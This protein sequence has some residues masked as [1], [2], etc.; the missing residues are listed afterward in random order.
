MNVASLVAGIEALNKDDV[1]TTGPGLAKR[2][3]TVLSGAGASIYAG[4]PSTAQ[5]TASIAKRRIAGEVLRILQSAD[6][7]RNFE[8]VLHVLEELELLCD[9]SAPPRATATLRPFVQI[10]DLG[11]SFSS[12]RLAL[13]RE[14]LAI[15]ELIAASLSGIDY[16]NWMPLYRILRPFLDEYNIRYF[17]LNYDVLTDV[18]AEILARRAA[19][20]W[21]DGFG[22][23]P[24]AMDGTVLFRADEY[25]NPPFERPAHITVGHLHGSICYSYWSTDKRLAHSN[26]FE[27][28][29]APSLQ[30][31]EENWRIF[32]A[33]ANQGDIEL[34]S[35]APIVSGLRK[36]DKLNLSPYGNY[37]H[38]FVESLSNNPALLLIGYGGNDPH[39]NFWLREF[40]TIH[41]RRA[42]VIDI[43]AESDP[44]RFALS[45]IGRD[46]LWREGPANVW[47][48]AR[49]VEGITFVGGVEGDVPIARFLAHL[50]SGQ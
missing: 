17:T 49:G 32:H 19:K 9:N 16:S 35:V 47:T 44:G 5:L 27:I 22:A 33:L 1:G 45:R 14:R 2:S 11:K 25:A 50:A 12:D 46:L 18:V 13:R 21:Y 39:V 48:N 38:A 15:L 42:R 30:R 4:A 20:Y 7:S 10:S 43:T 29:S 26:E 28:A 40:T 6:P 36:S 41:V 24:V 37:L 8:D 3:L 23:R 34:G 31:A